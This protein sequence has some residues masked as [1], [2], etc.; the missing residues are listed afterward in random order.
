MNSEQQYTRRS[1]R[2]REEV[3]RLEYAKEHANKR[4]KSL[5]SGLLEYEVETLKHLKKYYYFTKANY[6]ELSLHSLHLRRNDAY[7]FC[8]CD[9]AKVPGFSKCKSCVDGSQKIKMY[10]N[11]F[12]KTWIKEICKFLDSSNN[13]QWIPFTISCVN[14]DNDAT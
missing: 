10:Y 12:D 4:C 8:N 9:A 3:D 1:K 14:M 7:F 6:D 5:C 11:F 13:K 2:K